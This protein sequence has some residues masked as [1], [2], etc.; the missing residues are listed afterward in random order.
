MSGLAIS[1]VV[2]ALVSS[3]SVFDFSIANI[4]FSTDT[5]IWLFDTEDM[6]YHSIISTDDPTSVIGR[7]LVSADAE[8]IFYVELKD[9]INTLYRYSLATNTSE[10]IFEHPNLIHITSPSDGKMFI[11]LI[12]ME[13]P[14]K[15]S[16]CLLSV[17]FGECDTVDIVINFTDFYWLDHDIFLTFLFDKICVYRVIDSE[18]IEK[19]SES[20][21]QYVNTTTITPDRKSIMFVFENAAQGYLQSL[22]SFDTST[23]EITTFSN[24]SLVDRGARVLRIGVSPDGERLAYQIIQDIY[25][26]DLSTGNLISQIGDVWNFFWSSGNTLFTISG[27]LDLDDRCYQLS[28]WNFSHCTMSEASHLLVEATYIALPVAN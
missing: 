25:V 11:G 5:E 16:I 18:H 24:I 3:S 10:A 17:Q 13:E 4:F 20:N 21:V 7:F 22:L 9:K 14:E 19:I 2:A 8:Q 6:S 28:Q 15:S 27:G 26:V 1:L 23:Y 12:D